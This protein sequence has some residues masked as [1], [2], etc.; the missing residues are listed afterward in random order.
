M[1]L[2]DIPQSQLEDSAQ[3][4]DALVKA[5]S[6]HLPAN[7][8][9]TTTA[10][11]RP[12]ECDGLSAYTQIPLAV[13]LP[14]NTEQVQAIIRC[15]DQ[16]SIPIVPR[17]AGTG[18]S[19]GATP[20]PDGL[21]L[22]FSKLN[23]IL[24][25]DI[26]NRCAVLQPGVRNQYISDQSRPY[27]LYFAP[28]PSSQIACSIGG[29]F[30]E[31]S[32]G[33][34]CLKYGLTLNNV[35]GAKVV[36]PNGALVTLGGKT[37][38]QNGLD[39]LALFI[40]SE[41]LLGVVTEVTVKLLPVPQQE[42]VLLAGF[43]DVQSAA[44]CVNDII[45]HG[46]IPAGLEMMDQFA[47][48]AAEEYAHC[49]YPTECGAILLCEVDGVEAELDEQMA[50][51]IALTE[52]NHAT[53]IKVSQNEQERL[54][55]WIGRKSAFP[56]LGSLSADYYCMDGTIPRRHL[57]EVLTKIN[58]LSEQYDLRVANVF[59][60][61]DGNLHPLILYDASVAGELERC[62]ELGSKILEMCVDYGGNITG[63]HGVGLE[64]IGQMCHQFNV[65]EI[66]QFATVKLAID[67]K[68][69]FNPGKAI[70]TLNRC[71][72]FGHMHVH[73]NQTAH[74]ELPRF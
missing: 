41:G 71:A 43:A 24:D 25:L 37:L 66:Q 46:I 23:K 50:Q 69:L 70:P 61:G 52:Q 64:K 62:E 58:A 4:R 12:Y 60:A 35:L 63:E 22:S 55:L 9:L 39:L 31:N 65:A 38:D 27:G 68:S 26:E 13:A 32:G 10:Q 49:G 1:A 16:L 11:T 73:N 6:A 36:L 48:T 30:A 67:G 29:N 19:G 74:P 17:G 15:C 34:H 53:F 5:L 42:K 2:H 33:L 18:L 8:L 47:L 51:V 59:H 7:G 44:N 40:G 3:R 21:L 28:D 56:A 57:A 14:E 20:H 45:A 72:E 54:N